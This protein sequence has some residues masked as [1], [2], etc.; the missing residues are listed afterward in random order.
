[1]SKGTIISAFA[2][3]AV[4]VSVGWFVSSRLLK[5]R[6]EQKAE[7]EI[8]K[9]RE[10]YVDKEEKV[11]TAVKAK[12]AKTEYKGEPEATDAPDPKAQSS[13][14]M[15]NYKETVASN[16]KRNYSG[17]FA[18]DQK[19]ITIVDDPKERSGPYMISPDDFGERAD[20][21]YDCET[22]YFYKDGTVADADNNLI[23]NYS[24]I[25]GTE[26]LNN[27]GYYPE[28]PYSVFVRND[29]LKLDVEIINL[30]DK[31][32]ADV[33]EQNPYLA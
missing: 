20:D 29:K 13:F 28:E 19:I 2:S 31:T 1:M 18:K 15:S 10:F 24:E 27:F 8:A 12:E 21:D 4:G 6:Y 32:W 9:V 26:C 23:D 11:K 25:V 16:A 14:D 33:V 7:E 17:Y 30:P 5:H 22:Y 3:F